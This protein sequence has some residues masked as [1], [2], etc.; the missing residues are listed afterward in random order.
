MHFWKT[1]AGISNP[2]PAELARDVS[3]W[4]S[5]SPIDKIEL[6]IGVPDSTVIDE[7]FLLDRSPLDGILL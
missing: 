7:S 4:Q 6:D 3:I 2:R 1:V 5:R